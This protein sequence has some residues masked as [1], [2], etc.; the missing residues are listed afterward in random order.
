MKFIKDQDLQ[1]QRHKVTVIEA[2]KAG[3]DKPVDPRFI[4]DPK[5]AVKKEPPKKKDPKV[6]TR[7]DHPGC[8]HRR[9][10]RGEGARRGLTGQG[11]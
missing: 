7:V 9:A 2:E 5:K 4:E 1:G 11:M 10:S 6:D 3:K 8:G